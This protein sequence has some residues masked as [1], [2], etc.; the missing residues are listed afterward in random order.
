MLSGQAGEVPLAISD[1]LFKIV[2]R[3]TST[4]G[5]EVLAFLYPQHGI[6]YRVSGGQDYNHVP[7]LTSVDV[8]EALTGLDFFTTLPNTVDEAELE[9]MVATDLW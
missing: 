4:G 7:H 8:V 1:A 3:D 5:V 9:R 6:D 2:S